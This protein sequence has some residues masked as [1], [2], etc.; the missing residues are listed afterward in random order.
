MPTI[1][2]GAAYFFRHVFLNYHHTV[3]DDDCKIYDCNVP[4]AWS[5]PNGHF[6][7]CS[8][9]HHDF[10]EA[11]A[12]R[13]A[14]F[15]VHAKVCTYLHSSTI[16]ATGF[17][18]DRQ[19]RAWNSPRKPSHSRWGNGANW[20]HSLH[21]KNAILTHLHLNVGQIHPLPVQQSPPSGK[22]HPVK[23]VLIC[24]NPIITLKYEPAPL[25]LNFPLV[26]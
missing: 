18:L 2:P 10:T 21:T 19:F 12:V 23:P 20:G 3:E 14:M 1:H 9:C 6:V 15:E 25:P 8:L 24:N 4:C 17:R 11:P 5:G 13:P 16:Y 22:T 26:Y 7:I